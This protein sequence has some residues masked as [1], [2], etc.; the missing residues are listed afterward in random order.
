MT[1]NARTRQYYRDQGYIA[2]IVE[3]H[4]PFPKPWGKKHDLLGIFDILLLKPGETWGVQATVNGEVP[5][6]VDKIRRSPEYPRWLAMGARVLVIGWAK[7]GARGK[8]K[9]WT[10][11]ALEMTLESHP[12]LPPLE[13]EA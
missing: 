12:P 5:R 1:P 3:H 11:T 9:L 7:L 4:S 13:P 2:E 10:P 6:R 8:R